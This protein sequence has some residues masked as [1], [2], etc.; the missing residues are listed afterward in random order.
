MIDFEKP[1]PPPFSS[2]PSQLG[3][4]SCPI[5][6]GERIGFWKSEKNEERNGIV[7]REK[8]V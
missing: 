1:L 6:K 7:I 8:W 3:L 4:R 5:A 2:D